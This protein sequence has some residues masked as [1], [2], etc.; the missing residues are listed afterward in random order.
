MTTITEDGKQK[1]RPPVGKWHRF[2]VMIGESDYVIDVDEA[3][4]PDDAWRADYT[5]ATEL[6]YMAGHIVWNRFYRGY[7]WIEGLW[8]EQ[9][10]DGG[11]Y[12]LLVSMSE[13]DP[14]IEVHEMLR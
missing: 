13:G 5:D 1:A 14:E 8:P 12:W 6:S 7:G 4:T 2:E 10:Q 11:P 3:L 9:Q